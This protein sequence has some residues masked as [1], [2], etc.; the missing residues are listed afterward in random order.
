MNFPA[1]LNCL[2]ALLQIFS[3]ERRKGDVK[4]E[5]LIK[6]NQ[7]GPESDNLLVVIRFSYYAIRAVD[8]LKLSLE[9]ND[10][11]L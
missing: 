10:L 7:V 11:W 2:N 1:N 4:F 5:T 9:N 3:A 8:V 6:Q